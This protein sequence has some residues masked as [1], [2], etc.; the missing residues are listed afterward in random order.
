MT[1]IQLVLL[2]NFIIKAVIFIAFLLLYWEFTK[3]LK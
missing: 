2:H 3:Y 1:Y